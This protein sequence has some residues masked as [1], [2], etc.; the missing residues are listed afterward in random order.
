MKHAQ[1]AGRYAR[2]LIALSQ[3]SSSTERVIIEL[4]AL[5][6]A[7]QQDPSIQDFLAS[8]AIS[9]TDKEAALKKALAQSKVS[10]E[11]LNFVLFLSQRDRIGLFSEIVDAF[12][13]SSDAIHGVTRGSVESAIALGP[14][15]RRELERIVKKVIQKEVI[16]NY[17]LNPSIIGGL[18]ARVGSYTFDDS[19]SSH[20][21]RMN[22]DL[23]RR[24]V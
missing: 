11:T 9:P 12:E 7:F 10:T 20:L 22:E 23:K 24:T 17:K 14:D 21:R 15:A 8:P 1:L 4:R 18:I 6:E 3:E 16:L 13:E 2:A 19:I 5:R